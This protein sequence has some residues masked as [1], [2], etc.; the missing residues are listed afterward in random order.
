M[1]AMATKIFLDLFMELN[2]LDDL[3]SEG[4]IIG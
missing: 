1:M 2:E 4:H 3:I